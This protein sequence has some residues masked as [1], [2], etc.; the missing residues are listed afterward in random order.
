MM[1]RAA[2]F[3]ELG[4][5]DQDFYMYC[6]DVDLCR[7]LRD[8][9]YR[10]AFFP[11]AGLT[12][13][14]YGSSAGVQERRIYQHA[15]S[16]GL[17]TRKHHGAGCRARRCRRSPPGMFAGR[18]AA[19]EADAPRPR[20]AGAFCRP[21][22]RVAAPR[23]ATGDRGHRG[24]AKRGAGMSGRVVVTGGLGFIGSELVRALSADGVPVLNIDLDTYAG[25]SRRL[26][27][28]PADAVETVTV[29]VGDPALTGVIAA[30]RPPVVFHLAAETHVTR[31]E[32]AAE[33]FF[34]ANVD[35][36]R[37]VL[38]AARGRGGAAGGAHV[39]RRGLRAVSRRAVS[40][41]P[42]APGRG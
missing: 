13:H 42:E 40:R 16:R 2:A 33:V 7:R 14:E 26:A 39:H 3:R 21:R 20:G 8:A 36:T 18:I 30:E 24:G 10:V 29:D 37:R 1:I 22:A 25:D 15:R 31:S 41:G 5:F 23:R 34:H 28:V 4:G 38:E 9:G 17:Y 27:A 6:E 12:H 19:S 11:P 35:G 32:G